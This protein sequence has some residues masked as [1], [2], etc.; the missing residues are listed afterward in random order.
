MSSEH[1]EYDP[2]SGYVS[3]QIDASTIIG[4]VSEKL[5]IWDMTRN[6]REQW[7]IFAEQRLWGWEG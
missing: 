1:T 7:F 2:S 4:V 5:T 3:L 6:L